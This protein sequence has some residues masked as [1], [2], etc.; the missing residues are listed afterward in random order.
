MT[1]SLSH[2]AMLVRAAEG[3]AAVCKAAEW[4]LGPVEDF[5]SE[6]TREVYVG[7]PSSDALLLLMEAI[8][9]GPYRTAL[10]KRGPGLHHVGVNVASIDDYVASLA[11]TGWL[12]H[13]AS[14]RTLARRKTVCLAR[15]GLGALVE[16]TQPKKIDSS[17]DRARFISEV[18]VE[19]AR[20]HQRLL[21]ALGSAGPA[22]CRKGRP[23]SRGRGEA[24]RA[25][26][27]CARLRPD[28]PE[29]TRSARLAPW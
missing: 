18:F 11:G 2:V 9:P 25:L 23:R 26:R 27:A 22:A 6:G 10:E 16:V 1:S 21:D 15:P 3:A 12:V 14:I 28:G 29:P 7:P 13:P 19:G 20:E 8:G 17:R 5:P 4:E 24:S